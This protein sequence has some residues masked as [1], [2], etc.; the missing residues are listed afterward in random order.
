MVAYAT[1]IG[2]RVS[3][4]YS[5]NDGK[6]DGLAHGAR[7]VAEREITKKGLELG[8]CMGRVGLGWGD[9]FIQPTK[10]GKKKFN[11]TQPIT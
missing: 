10:V 4:F 9:F 1:S 6:M 5:S 11:P 8:V 2:A 3:N 7:K